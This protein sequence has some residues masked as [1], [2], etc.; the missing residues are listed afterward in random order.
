[1]LSAALRNQQLGLQFICNPNL[2][3]LYVVSHPFED[4]YNIF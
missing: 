3:C 1:M 2:Y 4:K